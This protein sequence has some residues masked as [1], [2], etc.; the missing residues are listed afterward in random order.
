MQDVV[1]EI[2]HLIGHDFHGNVKDKNEV[3]ERIRTHGIAP[4]EGYEIVPVDERN[5]LIDHMEMWRKVASKNGQRIGE[6]EAML[7]AAKEP[8]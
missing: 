1:E 4:P 6:L 8:T 3:L 5:L 7:T 2:E